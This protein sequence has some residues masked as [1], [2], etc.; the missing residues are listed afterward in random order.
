M[1]GGMEQ[2]IWLVEIRLKD[3]K[4]DL[5]TGGRIVSF[6]EVLAD[7]DHAARHAAYE[8]FTRRSQYEPVT[9]QKML[10]WGLSL[11]DVCAPDAVQLDS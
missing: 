4:P 9:R 2:P 8:Q 5:P 7:N 10:R 11:A 1:S 3:W 6:E